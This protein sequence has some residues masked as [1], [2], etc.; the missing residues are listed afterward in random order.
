MLAFIRAIVLHREFLLTLCSRKPMQVLLVLSAKHSIPKMKSFNGNV[1]DRV[2][3]GR[4]S[5]D[6]LCSY[7]QARIKMWSMD[8]VLRF[9]T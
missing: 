8:G 3:H 2:R 7:G 4:V 9:M 6:E 5:I 1:G